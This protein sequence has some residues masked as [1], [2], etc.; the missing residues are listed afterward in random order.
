MTV[1]SKDNKNQTQATLRL[2][3]AL[4]K[5]IRMEALERGITAQEFLIQAA[6]RHLKKNCSKN[7]QASQ[8]AA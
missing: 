7:T 1:E 6:I 8:T 4:W 3:R 5:S 2:D